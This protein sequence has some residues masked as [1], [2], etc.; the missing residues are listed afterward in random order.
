MIYFA[1]EEMSPSRDQFLHAILHFIF[2]L[3]GNLFQIP[4]RPEIPRDPRLKDIY[5]NHLFGFS[6]YATIMDFGSVIVQ[7]DKQSHQ[8]ARGSS[9]LF[10]MVYPTLLLV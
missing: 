3:F 9:S 8:V 1:P 6:Y 5:Q 2:L 10:Y 4:Q 7:F